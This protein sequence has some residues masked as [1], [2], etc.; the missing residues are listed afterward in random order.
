MK[1]NLVCPHCQHEQDFLVYPEINVGNEP[2][3]KNSVLN[4]ELF[5]DECENCQ[6]IIPVAYQTIYHDFE[7]KLIVVLDPTQEKSNQDVNELL[8]KEFGPLEGYTIRLVHNPDD[9]KEKIQ[10]RDSHLDDRLIEIAK[11]YY[12][13]NAIEQD[14]NLELISVLFNR[15]LEAHEIVLITKDQQ[16]LKAELNLD[17]V[18]HMNTLY[19]KKILQYTSAGCNRIDA[20][21]AHQLLSDKH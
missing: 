6:H 17:I 18:G 4:F 5:K 9:L 20:N 11:Q 8:E 10:L 19:G 2:G 7:Q 21:W 3:L 15:G 16:K 12:V 14:P 13:V 1:I